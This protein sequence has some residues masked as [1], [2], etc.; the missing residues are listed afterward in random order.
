MGDK[1]KIPVGIVGYGNLGKA[2]EKCLKSSDIFECKAIFSK[3]DLPNTEKAENIMHYKNKISLLF[4]CGGSQN[5]LESQAHEYIK[6]FNIIE[7]YD[8]HERLEKHISSLNNFALEGSKVALCSFGWD[9]GLF[10]FMR[11]LFDSLGQP[12]F[13]FWG[14]GLSQGHT[15]AIKNIENVTDA[16]QFTI[17]YKKYLQKVKQG[18]LIIQTKSFHKRLCYVVAKKGN[19]KRIR[20]NIVNMEGYFKGYNTKVHFTTQRHLNKL[21]NFKHQGQV[22]TLQ[23]RLNFSLKI[24]SNPQF[25]AKILVTFAKAFVTLA[26]QK[27]FGAYTIFDIPLSYILENKFKYL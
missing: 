22:S 19:R 11:G 14:K 13:T 20:Q 1:M 7:S 26:N 23:N 6:S 8:N 18:K 4:L 2:V 12:P 27:K 24:P 3:R 5:E 15:Q 25:T 10:S 16:I 21:K 9:P 17:P